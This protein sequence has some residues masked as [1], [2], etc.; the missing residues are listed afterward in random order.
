MGRKTNC[1]LLLI[2]TAVLGVLALTPSPLHAQ[3]DPEHEA[4]VRALRMQQ[5]SDPMW[6]AMMQVATYIQLYN[7]VYPQYQALALQMTPPGTR[8][9]YQQYNSIGFRGSFPWTRSAIGLLSF[10]RPDEARRYAAS[11]VSGGA[12]FYGRPGCRQ[13]VGGRHVIEIRGYP[14]CRGDQSDDQARKLL[15][16]GLNVLVEQA[17]RVL[18]SMPSPSANQ[19]P[20]TQTPPSVSAPPLSPNDLATV[21][22]IGSEPPTADETE[23]PSDQSIPELTPAE[24]ATAAGLAGGAALLGS[25]LM[26]GASGVR[27]DEAI[28]AIRDLLRGHLPE[29]PYEA[30][31][32]K[33]EALGWKY[34]EKDGVGT[35]DPVD[36]ARNEVGEIYSAERGGFVPSGEGSRVLTSAQDGDVNERGEVWSENDGGWVQ[37]AYWD[38]ERVR[39]AD[40]EA[41]RAGEIAEA[42][43]ISRAE[44]EA[45]S[46][47]TARFAER[48]AA[49]RAANEAELAAEKARLNQLYV[50]HLKRVMD[51]EMAEAARQEHWADVMATGEYASKLTLA[52]AKS[53][54]MVVAGPAGWIP[55]IVGMGAISS[56]EEGSRAWVAG[57]SGGKLAGAFAAGFLSGAKDGVVGRYVNMPRVSNWVKVLLPAELDT[58]ETLL[59]TGD[60]KKALTAGGLSAFGGALGQRL[61]NLGSPLAR[62]GSQL[63]LGGAMGALGRATC[64]GNIKEGFIDGLVSS[65][66]SS[67]GGRL[68]DA[69]A[70]MTKAQIQMDEEAFANAAEGRV[71]VD[72]LKHAIANG[73]PE[74]QKFALNRVLA[75]RDAKLLMK[76]ND[77]DADT[78]SAFATLTEEHR[79]KPLFE[80]TAS[81]LNGQT[82]TDDHGVT[83]NRFVVREPDPAKPGGFIEREVRPTDFK[84][85]SGSAGKAPG[86]DLD[87]YPDAT[88]IDKTTGR[89]VKPEHLERAVKDTCSDLRIS[90]SRQEINVVAGAHP[91]QYTL[92][93]GETPPQFL[94]RVKAGQVSGSEGRSLSEVTGFKLAEADVLHHGNTGAGTV[95][96]QCRTAIK[97]YD[98]ITSHLL[99]NIPGSRL[100]PVFTK[101]NAISGETPM[102]IMRAVYD[103]KMLPGTADARFQKATGMSLTAG[104]E[105]LAQLPEFLAKTGA[106]STTPAAPGS[107]YP[108]GMSPGEIL[109][110]TLRQ[111]LRVGSDEARRNGPQLPL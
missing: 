27:R 40:L 106:T 68:A 14:P 22:P 25:L 86:M 76:G 70:P 83:T 41:R 39:R 35:F 42:D 81:R 62:E 54:M 103:G 45:Y 51:A 11:T 49:E 80:G 61:G 6:Q 78:K 66:G 21:P 77:V 1:F 95:S 87:M 15:G 93:P 60:P 107:V 73:T 19:P 104:A 75:N 97:D 98:R 82:H 29:D 67:A 34:S 105:K 57:D 58:A 5:P 101:P 7:T 100:P 37:R 63:L 12:M 94:N 28:T 56:A 26:L 30:W 85:G 88:I 53:G 79:T 52:A 71:L 33:Y 18:Q 111:A 96:E 20:A 72:R 108:A 46:Q 24:I 64:D 38:Q 8:T 23:S 92:R 109:T 44:S 47:E 16:P 50:E 59:R 9:F 2:L 65:I 43:R 36:G 10:D 17:N 99:E 55:A 84:S 90:K 31:K 69:N 91:E 74:Q 4:L 102:D 110:A 3:Q 13:V 48:I 89:A 32:R